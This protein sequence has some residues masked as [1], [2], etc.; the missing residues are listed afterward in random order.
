MK[1]ETL[2]LKTVVILIGILILAL[3]I[4]W[5][6]FGADY[7]GYPILIGVYATEY[8]FLAL[9]QAL[10]LL[11]YIDK[12]KAFSELSVKTLKYIKYCAITISIIYAALIPFL[13][14]IADV[15]DAPGLIGFPIIFIFAS[16]VICKPLQLF[17]KSF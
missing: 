4:F 15:D 17:F 13:Y 2:F 6:P 5:L 8:H 3:C 9:Y 16:S 1:R 10:K 11:S 7:L 12:N 14:P